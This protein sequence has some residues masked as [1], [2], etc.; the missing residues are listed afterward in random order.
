MAISFLSVPYFIEWLGGSPKGI[1]AWGAFLFVQAMGRYAAMID[2]GFAI[3]ANR[4]MTRAHAAHD[5]N[6][7]WRIWQTA[8][9][10]CLAVGLVGAGITLLLG[11]SIPVSGLSPG[12][13]PIQ[14]FGAAAVGFLAETLANAVRTV[15][16]SRQ[17][18]APLAAIQGIAQLVGALCAIAAVYSTRHPAALFVG[19]IGVSGTLALLSLFAIRKDDRAGSGGV[20]RGILA[21]L[22]QF[23]VRAYPNHVLGIVAGSTDRVLLERSLGAGPLGNYGLASRIPE[24]ISLLLQPVQDTAQPILSRAHAEGDE[25]FARE[26]LRVVRM[27]LAIGCAFI[28]VPCAFADPL[29]KLWL[30]DHFIAGLAPILIGIAAFRALEHFNVTILLAFIA[31][32][33]PGLANPTSLFNAVTT[34]VFTIPAATYFGLQGVVW[35]KLAIQLQVLMLIWMLFRKVLVGRPMGPTL[36]LMGMT[37]LIAAA[38]TA[39]AWWFSSAGFIGRYPILALPLAPLWALTA[40]I[41]MAKFKLTPAPEILARRLPFLRSRDP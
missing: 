16:T 29:L 7:F 36:R 13:L 37:V 3:G 15:L 39:V 5:S 22:W 17:L 11:V 35:M 2:S 20:D 19:P 8:M 9:R 12:Q 28:L 33:N 25:P 41:V 23:V 18:F 38:F 4:L 30:R 32:G 6:A 1:E 26:T 14:L 27:A 21:S 34:A 31:A 40:F 10:A 24:V